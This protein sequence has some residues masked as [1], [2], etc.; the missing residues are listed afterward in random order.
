MKTLTLKNLSPFFV[1]SVVA[2]AAVFIPSLPNFDDGKFNESKIDKN[3]VCLGNDFL[4]G[5]FEHGGGCGLRAI[6]IA[7]HQLPIPF[8][9][10]VDSSA[11]I[12]KRGSCSVDAANVVVLMAIYD[13]QHLHLGTGELR[14]LGIAG[15]C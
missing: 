12:S 9:A 6:F 10:P 7:A 14:S 13:L 1:L 3:T 8:L 11:P 4:V 15:L 2:V 5:Q